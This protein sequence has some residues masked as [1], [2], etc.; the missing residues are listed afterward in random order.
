MS[1]EPTATRKITVYQA[2]NI[3]GNH[4]VEFGNE[5]WFNQAMASASWF[6]GCSGVGQLYN[7]DVIRFEKVEVELW[8]DTGARFARVDPTT[9]KYGAWRRR[10]DGRKVELV[11]EKTLVAKRGRELTWA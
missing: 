7:K 10:E 9:G 5:E 3:S 8:F 11:A 6:A 4:I 2:F 1:T